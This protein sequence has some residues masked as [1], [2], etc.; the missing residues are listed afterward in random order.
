MFSYIELLKGRM[1]HI[2][3]RA[4]ITSINAEL[5]CSKDDD[6]VLNLILHISLHNYILMF[7]MESLCNHFN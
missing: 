1:P 7:S 5:H 3:R 6:D 4:M 2:T